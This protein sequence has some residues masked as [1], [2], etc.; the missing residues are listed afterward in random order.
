MNIIGD[1]SYDKYIMPRTDYFFVK[2][3]DHK[4]ITTSSNFSLIS[5]FACDEHLL[6][7]TDYDLNCPASNLAHT[8]QNQDILTGINK[9]ST[10]VN[11]V[12]FANDKYVCHLSQKRHINGCTVINDCAVD[13][14]KA[15]VFRAVFTNTFYQKRNPNICF[16]LLHQFNGFTHRESQIIFFLLRGK[17]ARMIG[18]RLGL[19]PRTIESY[20]VNIK[21][22]VGVT[23]L[24]DLI[25]L[26]VHLGL[27]DKIPSGLFDPQALLR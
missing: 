19:S 20:I 15:D 18:H 21:D 23:H 17:P 4:F 1:Q 5:G 9:Q 10:F 26:C 11:I 12:T 6:N 16:E 22:K 3:Q 13:L 8:F 27:C 7:V 24:S 2:D 14:K 25:E